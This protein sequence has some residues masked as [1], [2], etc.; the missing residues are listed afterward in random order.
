MLDG[1][2]KVTLAPVSPKR[3]KKIFW[4]LLFNWKKHKKNKNTNIL[5]EKGGNCLDGL[6]Q[7]ESTHH[8]VIQI[9]TLAFLLSVFLSLSL[10]FICDYINP[11]ESPILKPPFI[12]RWYEWPARS[13]SHTRSV[14]LLMLG[15]IDEKQWKA[16]FLDHYQ[17][18][19]IQ[20]L[21]QNATISPHLGGKKERRG[22]GGF[23][24]EGDAMYLFRSFR[25]S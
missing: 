20:V 8:H 4:A 16:F 5:N 23:R 13:W 1:N 11:F 24:P 25:P 9:T 2:N 10:L 22:Q 19:R 6:L 18:S 12:H 7:S 14:D 17:N 15:Q 3:S 21:M